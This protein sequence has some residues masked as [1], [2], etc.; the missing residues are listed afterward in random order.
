MTLQD[1]GTSENAQNSQRDG[2]TRWQAVGGEARGVSE[3]PGFPLL[4]TLK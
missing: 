4:F 1:R 3:D 2:H